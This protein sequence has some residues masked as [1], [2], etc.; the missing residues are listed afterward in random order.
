M[1]L[2]QSPIVTEL[3]YMLPMYMVYASG[4]TRIIPFI[5]P[6]AM[7]DASAICVKGILV[8]LSVCQSVSV[9]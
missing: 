9:K 4:F 5:V 3:E 1:K 8:R 6:A 7:S 2:S